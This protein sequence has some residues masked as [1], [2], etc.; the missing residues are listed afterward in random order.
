MGREDARG[1]EGL[2][3]TLRTLGSWWGQG[4]KA[5][6]AQPAGIRQEENPT[7]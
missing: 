1:G 5:E 2:G 3:G 6:R 4:R 7:A